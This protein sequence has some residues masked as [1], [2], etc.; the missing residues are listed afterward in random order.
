MA[1]LSESSLAA[2]PEGSHRSRMAI[3]A[4]IPQDVL[5]WAP[6]PVVYF[7]C[8]IPP[9][10]GKPLRFR[11]VERYQYLRSGSGSVRNVQELLYNEAYFYRRCIL[12]SGTTLDQSGSEVTEGYLRDLAEHTDH[13][14]FAAYD[15]QAMLVWSKNRTLQERFEEAAVS[16]GRGS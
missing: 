12:T 15:G 1:Y 10:K 5:P 14:L 6:S 2:Q 13:I 9:H 7:E 8:K 4:F 11:L 16:A 3:S